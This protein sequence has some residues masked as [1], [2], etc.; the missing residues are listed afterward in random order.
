MPTCRRLMIAILLS[1][2]PVAWGGPAAESVSEEA[3]RQWIRY[4]VPLPKQVQLTAAVTVPGSQIAVVI[5]GDADRLTSQARAELYAALDTEAGRG[6]TPCFTITLKVGGAEAAPLAGLPHRDQAYLIRPTA[7]GTGLLLVGGGERGLY[8]AAKTLQQLVKTKAAGGK[9]Q[10]PLVTITDWP[11]MEDRGFWGADSSM[12]LRWMSDRKL[13]YD[14]QISHCGVD[15]DK[16]CLVR[17]APYKQRMIDE[18]PTYGINPVPVVLHLEQLQNSGLFEAYP[19]LAGKNGRPGSIC[20]SNPLFVDILSQWLLLWR[21]KPGVKEVDVWMAENLRGEKGC[22]CASCAGENRNVLETRA[23]VAAWKKALGQQ[24]DLGLRIL[25]SEETEKSNPRV[26]AELPK[27]V[28]IWYYHSLFTYNASEKPMIRP[29]LLGAIKEG[30]W[31]GVCANVCAIVGTYQP[32]TGPHFIHFRMNEFVDKGLSGLLGYPVPTMDHVRFNAEAAAEWSWNAKGRSPHE[33]ARSWAV[34]QGFKDPARFAEWS[35]VH[36]PVA[37]D[38]YGSEFPSGEKRR[39]PG[40]VAELLKQGKLPELG[41]VLWDVYALP[42]GDIKSVEQLEGDFKH[43]ARSVEL[44]RELGIPEFLQESLVVQGYVNALKALWELKRIVRSGG[45]AEADKPA[46]GRMF[47]MY[48]E[49]LEQA[50]AALPAW[51][52]AIPERSSSQ[53]YTDAAVQVVTG[54]IAEM[55]ATAGEL[56][57]AGR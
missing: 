29:Y 28:K 15:K 50:R 4:L 22:Q 26:F 27:K 3:V 20:Y 37:W 5:P 31:L 40:K 21:G 25:T 57:C 17:Y 51:E 42:W 46:A 44:A 6:G 54:M 52:A 35:D 45:V 33:F 56:G 18:G 1:L 16:V 19:E 10:I 30:R 32:F 13:N 24:P 8:Y 9:V 36:G 41:V 47:K 38:V 12:H 55:K 39:F 7:D 14:E 49:G 2:T 48:L 53:K 11:D 23:I 43:A 34:R